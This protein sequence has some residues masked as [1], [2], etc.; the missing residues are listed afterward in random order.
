MA[1]ILVGV[2]PVLT[3][4]QYATG[5]EGV[6]KLVANNDEKSSP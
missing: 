5:M 1:H 3:L 4:A 2:E 6:A